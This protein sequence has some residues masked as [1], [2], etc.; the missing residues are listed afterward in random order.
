MSIS[1]QA[2]MSRSVS[3]G[4]GWGTHL[5]FKPKK[6]IGWVWWFTFIIPATQEAEI[7]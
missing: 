3:E 4:T 2:G 7:G 1:Q 6:G 5:E